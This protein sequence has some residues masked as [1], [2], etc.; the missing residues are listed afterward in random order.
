PREYIAMTSVAATNGLVSPEGVGKRYPLSAAVI[1]LIACI[2]VARVVLG[3]V[4]PP[5]GVIYLA[6]SLTVVLVFGIFWLVLWRRLN[7]NVFGEL[8][9]L[10]VALIVVHTLVPAASFITAAFYQ[11]G[12]LAQ[13][14]PDPVQLRAHL[15]RQVLFAAGVA[16]GY[17]L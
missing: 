3:A 7:D 16:A 2:L 1:V 6:P 10:Y 15:W 4:L 9:F 13:L 12:P 11:S 5:E 17:L 14:L 8:G